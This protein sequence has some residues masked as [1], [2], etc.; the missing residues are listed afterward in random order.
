VLQDDTSPSPP[1]QQKQRY[2]PLN[3]TSSKSKAVMVDCHHK[4]NDEKFVL[5]GRGNKTSTNTRTS[6]GYVMSLSSTLPDPITLSDHE[7]NLDPITSSP[8][9]VT[10]SEDYVTTLGDHVTSSRD[11]VSTSDD[12]EII[13]S[14]SEKNTRRK[15]RKLL[16][17]PPVVSNWQPVPEQRSD[18]EPCDH[19]GSGSTSCDHQGSNS[20]SYDYQESGSA[21][22]DPYD[23]NCTITMTTMKQAYSVDSTS[24]N[25]SSSPGFK[26]MHATKH[27]FPVKTTS[28]NVTTSSIV[29]TSCVSSTYS[30]TST[31]FVAS[32]YSTTS[33]SCVASTYT[34]TSTS[35][36]ASTYSITSTS[37]NTCTNSTSKKLSKN[38]NLVP[39]VRQPLTSAKATTFYSNKR[40][41]NY[42]AYGNPSTKSELTVIVVV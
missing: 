14:H 20:T 24:S 7:D 10:L 37:S 32:T 27:L 11:H 28:L 6:G 13:V 3:F 34:I 15:K 9:H 12:C 17:T 42:S 1:K 36:V 26:N 2:S 18:F 35:C 16:N 38:S 19:W 30:I 4:C 21:S 29:S 23:T 31:S 41:Y 5:F 8:H 22:C 39:L 33:T 25:I 40:T